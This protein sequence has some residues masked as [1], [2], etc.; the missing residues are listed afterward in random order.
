MLPY[1]V[2]SSESSEL[3]DPYGVWPCES[4]PNVGRS[5]CVWS[6]WVDCSGTGGTD[7]MVGTVGTVGSG[8]M[9]GM[10][11]ASGAGAAYGSCRGGRS[12]LGG[13][14][15]WHRRCCV[16]IGR[17]S[18]RSAIRVAVRSVGGCRGWGRSA[19]RVC[20]GHCRS[21]RRHCQVPER[22]PHTDQRLAS[23][24]LLRTGRATGVGLPF[25]AYCAVAAGGMPGA[26]A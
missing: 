17:S 5:N 16:L 21:R 23:E 3:S 18:V 22:L 19:I 7:G 12:V 26:G 10:E 11:G 9:L 6:S 4:L 2:G 24:Q 1:T 25:G 15:G 8:G 20:G 13:W 14:S